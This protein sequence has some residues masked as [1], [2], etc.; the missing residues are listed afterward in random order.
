MILGTQN[1]PLI[2]LAADSAKLRLVLPN[3][4]ATLHSLHPY[5]EVYYGREVVLPAPFNFGYHTGMAY[6]LSWDL[7]E[8]I[9]TSP[10]PAEMAMG[11]EDHLV[12]QW[13]IRAGW[14]DSLRH[15]ISDGEFIDYPRTR[16]T[17]AC[18]YT[19]HTRAVHQLKGVEE[20]VEAARWFMN[21]GSREVMSSELSTNE[22]HFP[23]EQVTASA[24]G[25][26]ND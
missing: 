26:T 10:I 6:F 8:W 22:W 19:E 5:N 25:C 13:F 17:W 21:E 15:W 20:F 23:D 2:C 9:A 11:H 18:R 4:L 14:Q 3:I 1:P 7:V 24:K 12:G 16:G